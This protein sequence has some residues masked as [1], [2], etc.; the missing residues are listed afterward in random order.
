MDEYSAFFFI[1]YDHT[2]N[3]SCQSFWSTTRPHYCLGICCYYSPPTAI[4]N[5]GPLPT[6]GA[7]SL[8]ILFYYW[9]HVFAHINVHVICVMDT[10]SLHLLSFS[11]FSTW[12]YE[13]LHIIYWFMF[14]IIISWILDNFVIRLC[15]CSVV[16]DFICAHDVFGI[17]ARF[18]PSI[19]KDEAIN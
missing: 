14:A 19:A 6:L 17:W 9:C 12:L 5:F 7:S 3:I 13:H 18:R 15:M 2:I 11:N 4:Y 10:D 1:N 16:F 8:I